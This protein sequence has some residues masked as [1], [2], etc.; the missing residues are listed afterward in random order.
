MIAS[1]ALTESFFQGLSIENLSSDA[2]AS[3]KRKKYSDDCPPDHGAIAPSL[4][5]IESSGMMR[6]SSTSSFVPIPEHSGQAPKGELNENER[7]SSSSKERLQSWQA[8][9]SLYVCSFSPDLASTKS[10]KTNPFPN[11]SAVSIESVSRDLLSAFAVRRSMTTSIVCFSCFLSFGG[12]VS[13]M[14]SPSTR[15]R[16]YPCVTSSAKRSTN[17]P[18][19]SR[20]TGANTWNFVVAGIVRI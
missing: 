1:L 2:S 11:L 14:I 3:S 7:G 17:S 8:R 18:L 4:I 19:R 10:S 20:I 12:S 13:V 6:S 15:A 16:E 9:C 5:E